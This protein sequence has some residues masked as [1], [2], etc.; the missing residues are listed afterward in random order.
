[1]A[2]YR[3]NKTCEEIDAILNSAT[4]KGKVGDAP[5]VLTLQGARSYAE[6]L[7]KAS[8]IC[9]GRITALYTTGWATIGA[10][11]EIYD[12]FKVKYGD[13]APTIT[14]VVLVDKYVSEG[15]GVST[16]RFLYSGDYEGCYFVMGDFEGNDTIFGLGAT[17]GDW[18]IA[19]NLRWAKIV[20]K[21]REIAGIEGEVTAKKLAQRLS[22]PSEDNTNPLATVQ[23]LESKT[24]IVASQIFLELHTAYDDFQAFSHKRGY[25]EHNREVCRRLIENC[26]TDKT[27]NNEVFFVTINGWRDGVPY[28]ETAIL[29]S[30]AGEVVRASFVKGNIDRESSIAASIDVLSIDAENLKSYAESEE[31]IF[32]WRYSSVQVPSIDAIGSESVSDV[33]VTEFTLEEITSNGT[34]V[35]VSPKLVSAI[36]NNRIIVIP[37]ESGNFIATNTFSLPSEAPV[38]IQ[39][40]IPTGR[41][42]Y[43]VVLRAIGPAPQTVQPDVRAINLLYGTLNTIN[44]A[45]LAEGADMPLVSSISINGKTYT[46]TKGAVDLGNIEGAGEQQ[47]LKTI[48]GNSIVGEGDVMDNYSMEI[49]STGT[50][51][52][53]SVVNPRIQRGNNIFP[54][55]VDEFVENNYGPTLKVLISSD[56]TLTVSGT[57]ADIPTFYLAYGSIPEEYMPENVVKFDDIQQADFDEDDVES[58][59]YI[60][61]RTHY[62]IPYSI[63]RQLIVDATTIGT[64]ISSIASYFKLG[65]VVYKSAD[66]VGVEFD[67]QN[68]GPSVFVTVVEELNSNG[69]PIFYLRHISGNSSSGEPIMFSPS[70]TVKTIDSAFIPEN[71]ATKGYV[72]TAI[73]EAITNVINAS[74]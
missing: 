18:I 1:M 61:N 57:I 66:M 71:F 16:T 29:E 69:F 33:Y 60:K 6:V 8:L 17:K 50:Y 41:V 4:P 54:L 70:G 21:Q 46:P 11:V 22:T 34:T 20:T 47:R 64:N 63:E 56:G 49:T 74:Y 40:Q 62:F 23:D 25:E 15:I 44:G 58:K 65:G 67:C 52:V 43:D 19:Q 35:N 37:G 14:K 42:I 7:S 13:N 68:S 32:Y 45:S 10:E 2:D 48:F 28:M 51:T 24:D 5:D 59:A 53:E 27:P 38:G 26:F 72:E 36:Y 30:Q 55:V 73:T 3:S 12:A 39:M 9:A 31:D